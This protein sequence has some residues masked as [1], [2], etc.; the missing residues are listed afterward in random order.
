MRRA[1]LWILGL[2]SSFL[3]FLIFAIYLHF[4]GPEPPGWEIGQ[5]FRDDTQAWYS[6]TSI[7]AGSPAAEAGLQPGD[8]LSEKDLRNLVFQPKVG[9]QYRLEVRRA[10][11]Q[12]TVTLALNRPGL[13]QWASGRGVGTIVALLRAA[14]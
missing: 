11:V 8:L 1:P 2:G 14:F 4:A 3:S 13:A 6:I 9:W 5:P 12:E 7:E 10:G